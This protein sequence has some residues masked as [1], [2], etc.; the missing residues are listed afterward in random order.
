LSVEYLVVWRRPNEARGT[1][2]A[3]T[4]R[5]LM[6]DPSVRSFKLKDNTE[7]LGTTVEGDWI[8][9]TGADWHGCV[10]EYRNYPIALLIDGR[11]GTA[12]AAACKSSVFYG[13]TRVSNA[14]N[15]TP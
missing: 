4:Y 1:P 13:S 8:D 9:D 12:T 5:N 11:D 3:D 10:R 6:T 14:L 7:I 2:I 15:S